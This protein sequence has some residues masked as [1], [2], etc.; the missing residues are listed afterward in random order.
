MT[1]IPLIATAALLSCGEGQAIINRIPTH[2]VT[3]QEYKE[4]VR[5]VRRVSPNRCH[6]AVQ[7]SRRW[8]PRVMGRDI[9]RRPYVYHPFW[10]HPGVRP[11]WRVPPFVTT[12]TGGITMRFYF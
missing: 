11:G 5:E 1:P 4:I 10:P 2:S 7:P 8:R 3:R 9:H 6:F 12:P